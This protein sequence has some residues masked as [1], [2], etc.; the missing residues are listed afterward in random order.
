VLNVKLKR[1]SGNRVAAHTPSFEVVVW[2]KPSLFRHLT[3]VPLLTVAFAGWKADPEMSISNSPPPAVVDVVLEEVDDVALEEVDDVAPEEVDD[4]APEEVDDVAPEEVDDVAPEDV[5]VVSAD[6]VDVT[7]AVE[8]LAVFAVSPVSSPHAATTRTNAANHTIQQI[9]RFMLPPRSM[10]FTRPT[11]PTATSL[12]LPF[13][14]RQH[15]RVLPSRH[16]HHQLDHRKRFVG[17]PESSLVEPVRILSET[18][19]SPRAIR[20]P[21]DCFY[22]APVPQRDRTFWLTPEPSAAYLAIS[23]GKLSWCRGACWRDLRLCCRSDGFASSYDRSST[24]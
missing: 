19:R 22:S 12:H 3:V 17:P 2:L 20:F 8:V 4:V 9:R 11:S 7:S 10:C 16:A 14:G 23:G 13:Q 18:V 5:D 15:V 21:G 24:C 6:V 1:S